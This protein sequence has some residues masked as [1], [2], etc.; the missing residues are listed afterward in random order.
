MGCPKCGQP[1][2][3]FNGYMTGIE[4]SR[5]KNGAETCTVN[6][7][8]LHSSYNPQNEAERFVNSVECTFFPKAVFINEPAM[9]YC[10]PFLR[11]RFPDSKITAI[12]YS[13]VFDKWNDFFDD[14]LY[15]EPGKEQFFET[16]LF[17]KNGED[18]LCASL[19]LSWTPSANAFPEHEKNIWKSI[20]NTLQKCNALIATKSCFSRRWIKN[21][22]TFCMNVKKTA[23]IVPFHSPVVIAASGPSIE[24]ALSFLQKFR[25]KYILLC[26]SSALSI[27]EKNN[28]NP[29]FVLSTDGGWWAKVHLRPLEK[30]KIIPLAL[31][32]EAAC[33][34]NI[35]HNSTIIPLD[36]SDGIES[37]I[38]HIWTE[39]CGISCLKAMR[40]GTVSG[41]AAELALSLT[42]GPVF[43]CGLDLAENKGFQHAQP[44][45]IE[46]KASSTDTRIL[47]TETRQAK[48]RF[49]SGSLHIY[50][51]WFS[52]ESRR[53]AERFFRLSNSFPYKNTLGN[54][55]DADFSLF[56]EKVSRF[57]DADKKC[58]FS[59]EKHIQEK[60][61][62][63]VQQ[64]ISSFIDRESRTERW[65]KTV[66][67]TD[68]IMIEK[69]KDSAEKQKKKD[70]LLRKNDE[71]SSELRKLIYG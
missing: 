54:I 22:V 5:S 32:P 31:P 49:Y 18:V 39:T 25:R 12:R 8:F 15:F 37:E 29:D 9:S 10:I 19:F 40:N 62:K 51:D 34:K 65:L 52:A 60:D 42:D 1:V 46:T 35:L 50:R 66:F 6:N 44:N 17:Q 68:V 7:K 64:K 36:Y 63:S 33:Q 67:P 28:I 27:L 13:R 41:T 4:F 38:L 24:G 69:T 16:Q 26:V 61:I 55:Q 70:E 59:C 57:S 58:L 56:K 23:S 3:L 47:T 30:N 2:F 20:K 21:A 71:F 48:S 45:M 53:L 11:A 43:A 14:T